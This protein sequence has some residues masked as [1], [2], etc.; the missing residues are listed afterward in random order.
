MVRKSETNAFATN[1]C[2]FS[3]F[4][5]TLFKIKFTIL[6]ISTFMVANDSADVLQPD[7]VILGYRESGG[8]LSGKTE[9]SA[10]R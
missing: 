1:L 7:L 3:F 10:Q 9:I 4:K 8:K 2:P 5:S 6:S